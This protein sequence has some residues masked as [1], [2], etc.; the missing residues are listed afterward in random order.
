MNAPRPA[1]CLAIPSLNQGP[2]VIQALKSILNQNDVTLKL[3]FCDGGSRDRTL[4]LVRTYRDQFSFFRSSPDRGQAAAI[5][6]GMIKIK[7]TI[8]VTWLNAD[9]LLL[10]QG[11]S[12]MVSFLDHHPECVAVFGR[13]HIIDEEGKVIRE[14]P[15][16]PFNQK[17]FAVNC[18]ICQPASLIRR[19]AWQAVGGLDESIQTSMDYDLW[20]RL[21]K[22]GQ[23]GYFEQFVACSRDHSQSKTRRLRKK[24]N[25]EAVAILLKHWGMVP[26]N[27]CAAN[28]LEN[29]EPGSCRA[30]WAKRWEATKLY[31]R[32]NKWKALLPQNWLL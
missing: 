1:I 6:E 15:T 19:S 26:R 28:I 5:N 12:R 32:I 21:S 23:I 30:P 8:Y 3:A 11:L 17:A 4:S 29:L 31:F 2:F 22:M 14:Y 18:M 27:W 20:W 13:A 7:D 9:D 10:P 24:V 25:D 16:R